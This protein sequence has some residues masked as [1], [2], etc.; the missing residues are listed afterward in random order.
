M[1]KIVCTTFL[2][3]WSIKKNI[4]PNQMKRDENS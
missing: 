4:D 3:T 1:F 2:M